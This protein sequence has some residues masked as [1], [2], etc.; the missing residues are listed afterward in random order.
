MRVRPGVWAVG[1]LFLAWASPLFAHHAFT[2]E[3]DANKPFTLKGKV[4]RFD[5]SN[6]HAHFSI[7]VTIC[8]CPTQQLGAPVLAGKVVCI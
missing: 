2:A 4:T 8:R 7:D 6:P 1:I 5:W 3:F